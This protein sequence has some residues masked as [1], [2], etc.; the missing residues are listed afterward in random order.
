MKWQKKTHKTLLYLGLDPSSCQHEGPI[1]HYPVIQTVPMPFDDPIIQKTFRELQHATH[2]L[3]TS[4]TAVEIFFDYLRRSPFSSSL[5][6][7]HLLAVGKATAAKI[8][9]YC[10]YPIRIA[11]QE[12]SEGIIEL[13][14]NIPMEDS[15]TVWPHSKRSRGVIQQFFSE[16]KYALSAPVFYT[17]VSLEIEELPDLEAIDEI[18]FTSPSCVDAMKRW[19][20]TI[21]QHIQL[22]A[23]GPITAEYLAQ[24]KNN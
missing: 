22:Q 11:E 9:Q 15:K 21:P 6:N 1:I 20:R 8:S 4:K 2:L 19:L 18:L 14:Q 7:Q 23:I 13:L 17:T 5:Q 16:K 12:T 24:M 3:F 10:S